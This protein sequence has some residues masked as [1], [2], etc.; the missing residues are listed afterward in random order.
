MILQRGMLRLSADDNVDARGSSTVG[1]QFSQGS[2][3]LAVEK[4]ESGRMLG[5]MRGIAI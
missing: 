1:Q 3:V 2:A 4:D 5:G